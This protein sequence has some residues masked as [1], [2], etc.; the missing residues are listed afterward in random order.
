MA[1]LEMQQ[2]STIDLDWTLLKSISST[3]EPGMCRS[4]HNATN[5]L[6]TVNIQFCAFWECEHHGIEL[7]ARTGQWTGTVANNG[8]YRAGTQGAFGIRQE[9]AS[10]QTVNISNNVVIASGSGGGSGG[11][12]RFVGLGASSTLS[13]NRFSSCNG[14]TG[15]LIEANTTGAVDFTA[16]F[17]MPTWTNLVIHSN[18]FNGIRI[19]CGIGGI[20]SGG[21]IWRNNNPGLI[22]VAANSTF[23]TDRWLISGVTLFGNVSS[24]IAQNQAKVGYTTFRSCTVA[25]DTTFSTPNGFL[26]LGGGPWR[27]EN[28]SFGVAVGILTTHTSADISFASYA[29]VGASGT[30]AKDIILVDTTLGSATELSSRSGAAGIFSIARQR[31]DGTVGAH[32][33][34]KVLIGTV[35]RD[36]SLFRTAPPSEKLTP[37]CL[38]QLRLESGSKRV[39][40]PNGQSATVS[41][42]VQKDGSYSGSQPRLR[43]RANPSIG[44][45]DDQTIDTMS[46][47]SGVWEQLTGTI[48][49]AATD[50]GVYEVYVDC[51]GTAGNVYI[52][53]W[54][55][56]LA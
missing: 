49:P 1:F 43:A 22:F 4:W 41:I 54:S 44:L 31:S 10:Q 28:C 48:T 36:T 14:L 15:L 7:R 6:G 56:T 47:G 53:D 45:D 55:V 27:F 17:N 32:T 11:G 24:N 21:S 33:V 20:I 52:D 30:L 19:D 16:M 40:V 35:A 50:D 38:T 51:N 42:Y 3:S 12:M 23:L 29:G 37:A 39:A 46:G 2:D 25:G 13:G 9:N 34:E 26:Y 18:A 8:F 5:I